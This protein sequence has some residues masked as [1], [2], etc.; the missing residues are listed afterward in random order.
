MAMHDFGESARECDLLVP[1]SRL[2][3]ASGSDKEQ[4]AK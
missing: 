4:L 3:C 2:P 1:K